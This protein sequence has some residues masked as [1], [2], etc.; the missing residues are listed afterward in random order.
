MSSC[1]L[2][3]EGVVSGLSEE[4]GRD[5]ARD[6]GRRFQL[7]SGREHPPSDISSL[8]NMLFTASK[9]QAY[10]QNTPAHTYGIRRVRTSET[11]S[12]GY[13]ELLVDMLCRPSILQQHL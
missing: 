11:L 5:T 7:L 8:L 4:L 12:S 6:S 1:D 9:S 2:C 3:S 13:R 10:V